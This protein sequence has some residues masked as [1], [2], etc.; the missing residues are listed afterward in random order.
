MPLTSP[1]DLFLA[2]AWY[3]ALGL[4]LPDRDV[5][6]PGAAEDTIG[7][8]LL[9][10]DRLLPD[11]EERCRLT[12][13]YLSLHHGTAVTD[14]HMIP[15]VVVL[16]WTAT[17]TMQGAWNTFA[18]PRLA[19]RPDLVRGGAVNVSAHFL[20]DR[21]GTIYRLLPED[22]AGRHTI[23]MNHV[24]IGVENVGDGSAHPLTDAQV[25]ANIA[26]VRHLAGRYPITHLIG[27]HEYRRMEGTDLFLEADPKYRNVKIDPGEDFMARIR[28]GLTDLGLQGPP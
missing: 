3:V 26:L 24:A 17:S 22:R 14:C 19:G 12:V 20:V 16:H 15:R 6:P 1:L 9:I 13:E 8:S 2:L 11:D 21:D 25:E 4:G 28:A 5:P 23:G 18:P 10:Q 7:Q 27:H